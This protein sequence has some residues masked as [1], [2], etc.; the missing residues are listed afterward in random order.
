MP[1]GSELSDGGRVSST[2]RASKAQPSASKERRCTDNSNGKQ[3][4]TE[5]ETSHTQS[6]T[7]FIAENKL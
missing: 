1:T 6:T 5:T 3:F 2:G 4:E 7:Q